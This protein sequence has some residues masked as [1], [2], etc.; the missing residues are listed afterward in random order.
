MSSRA[1]K[2]RGRG[3]GRT[4]SETEAW[5][6]IRCDRHCCPAMIGI[7][8]EVGHQC[9]G[10]LSN[11]VLAC[12]P[13]CKKWSW[14]RFPWPRRWAESGRFLLN[15]FCKITIF[16]PLAARS[17]QKPPGPA[18]RNKVLADSPNDPDNADKAD[19]LNGSDNP[20]GSDDTLITAWGSYPNCKKSSWLRFPW[21]R[22]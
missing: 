10:A 13:C 21:P 8:S 17:P 4:N 22:Q 19:D 15:A 2:R 20:D 14:P 12:W 16:R 6:C 5:E 11:M 9:G 7:Y 1:G 3:W 18:R